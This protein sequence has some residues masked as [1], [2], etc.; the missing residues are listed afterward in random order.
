LPTEK[1]IQENSVPNP[2]EIS[3]ATNITDNSGYIPEPPAI[4]DESIILNSLGEPTLQS[5]GLGSYFWPQGW[6]QLAIE[7]FHV[8]CDLPWYQAIILFAI[9]L[10]TALFFLITI[11]A[12]KNAAVMRRLSPITN[13]LREKMSDAR[14]SGDS[15]R[16][17]KFKKIKLIIHY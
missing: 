4:F 9:S 2:T 6:V 8:Y 14:I 12:Q 5:L 3:Q 16:G 17:L 15:L 13:K 11:K 7:S 10:R 1:A